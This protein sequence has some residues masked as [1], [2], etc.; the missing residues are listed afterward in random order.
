MRALELSLEGFTSFRSR[1]ILDF[2]DLDLFAITGPT[3]AGKTSLLDAMTYA[4]YGHVA[5]YN[6]DASAKEIVSL[7][8]QNLKVSF[9]FS[10][11]GV[12]Y[13]VTRT[14]RF[15]PKTP[16]S[17]AILERLQNGTAEKLETKEKSVT[18]RVEQILGMD[19]ETFT[20]VILLPQ[21][22]F[23]E[24]IKGNKAKRREI[25][26]DLAGFQIFE[27]M[28]QQAQEQAN[29]FKQEY[30]ILGRQL[31]ELQLP[32]AEEVAA[33]QQEFQNV[34]QQIPSL[35]EAVVKAQK[36][37]DNEE[38]LLQDILRL[39]GLETDLNQLKAKKDE[40]ENLT[41]HL[42]QAREADQI[43]DRYALVK[44]A[45][46]TY[47]KVQATAITIQQRLSQAKKQLEQQK[48]HL[49]EVTNRYNQM[50]PQLKARE[51][52]LHSAKK[53]EEQRQQY[54][55]EL[56]RI[57]RNWQQRQTNLKVAK[58][59][60][61]SAESHLELVSKQVEESGKNLKKYSP[62]G[63][64][65]EQLRQVSSQLVSYKFLQE[66]TLNSRQ[67]LEK[68]LLDK[69]KAEKKYQETVEKLQQAQQ[70]LQEK[71]RLLQEAEAANHLALQS[72]HAA[73]LRQTLHDSDTCP[74]CNGIYREAELL[75]LPEVEQIETAE[76]STQKEAAEKEYKAADKA[77]T[78]A[79]ATVENYKQKE[80]ESQHELAE[81]EVK[82]I[83][84]K[85][86]ISAILQTESWEVDSLRQEL[87]ELQES[88]RLY[89]QA[90]AQQKEAAAQVRENQQALEAASKT[91]TTALAECE[92]SQQ[93]VKRWEQQLQQ[94]EKQ[95]REIT[96]GRSSVE[97]QA[98]LEKDRQKFE[99]QFY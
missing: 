52:A 27:T 46:E 96:D 71:Q 74:V 95:I 85:Q 38:K 88:D 84:L 79:E 50:E 68:T 39:A 47:K 8:S 53:Y 4:L 40:I 36:A 67:K 86:E 23:D 17:Q 5:R 78:K 35:N 42:Q 76:L 65:L 25:L 31:E 61:Q 56:A 94:V 33:K 55:T 10:V 57:N 24:F 9:R 44:T 54:Q 63:T 51:E 98:E 73:A 20:R 7:G 83:N 97:L 92:T 43:K 99:K 2:S 34:E 37:L 89:H 81:N 70:V 12:E 26:R 69:Q 11:R 16:D 29:K 14:W 90:L 30:Q 72:N 45:R 75:P 49:D 41:L 15:R 28:R 13:R 21:G 22:K 1:Q 60:L 48:A 18:K 6:K 62:G 82:L 66:Q 87:E 59:E 32:T 93:E 64:R 91:H 3:G 19:Y 77:V 58:Q 80:L